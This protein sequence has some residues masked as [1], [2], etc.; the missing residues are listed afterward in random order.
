MW[1]EHWAGFFCHVLFFSSSWI[2]FFEGFV[3]FT[4]RC[5]GD[6]YAT[7]DIHT[8]LWFYIGTVALAIFFSYSL[9]SLRHFL[10]F[11]LHYNIHIQTQA[12]RE[13]KCCILCLGDLVS[14]DRKTQKLIY[15]IIYCYDRW[16]CSTTVFYLSKLSSSWV[17]IFLFLF[18]LVFD[19]FSWLS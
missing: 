18:L 5:F 9:V 14:S 11:T 15:N 1:T 2:Q 17:H 4:F 12:G 10:S 6:F 19:I 13:K 3:R 8:H 7:Q 16:C